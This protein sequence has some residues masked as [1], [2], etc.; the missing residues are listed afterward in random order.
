MYVGSANKISQFNIP[1]ESLVNDIKEKSF[2][3][4][5]KTNDTQ[6]DTSSTSTKKSGGGSINIFIFIFIL[7]FGGL[8][9]KNYQI[10][11]D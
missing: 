7:I 8:L 3:Y 6:D 1:V 2:S 10:I 9:R 5:A 4:L 11:S